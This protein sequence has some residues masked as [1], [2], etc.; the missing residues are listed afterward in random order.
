MARHRRKRR[1]HLNGGDVGRRRLGEGR[2]RDDSTLKATSK[3]GAQV[4]EVQKV[5]ALHVHTGLLCQRGD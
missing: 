5:G 4:W 1:P 3:R 2:M